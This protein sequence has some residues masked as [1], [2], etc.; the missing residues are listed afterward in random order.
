MQ[1]A[2]PKR[3]LAV[4]RYRLAICIAAGAV[5]GLYITMSIG[6]GFGTVAASV[7]DALASAFRWVFLEPTARYR[8]LGEFIRDDFIVVPIC[9]MSI[10]SGWLAWREAIKIIK[11]PAPQKRPPADSGARHAIRNF[12]EQSAYGDAQLATRGKIQA[13]L[14]GHALPDAPKFEE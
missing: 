10:G 5:I 4:H 14:R 12:R 8:D 2:G 1:L 7:A 11:N 9:V 13:A 6:W 3:S